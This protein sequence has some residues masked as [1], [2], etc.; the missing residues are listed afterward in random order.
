[1]PYHTNEK[2]HRDLSAAGT[3]LATALLGGAVPLIGAGG[4][5]VLQVLE[6][7]TPALHRFEHVTEGVVDGSVA[8]LVKGL[9]S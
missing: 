1:M 2:L 5:I 7:T 3:G 6:P 9:F 4:G 8:L